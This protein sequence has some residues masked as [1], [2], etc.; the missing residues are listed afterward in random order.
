MGIWPICWKGSHPF[1]H[2]EHRQNT[3]S[4]LS[5]SNPV[6]HVRAFMGERWR[7]FATW[8]LIPKEESNHNKCFRTGR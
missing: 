1:R 3:T 4:Q 2:F 8:K 5:G 6:I 7:P